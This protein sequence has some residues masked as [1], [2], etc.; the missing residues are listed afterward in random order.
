[1]KSIKYYKRHREV[2]SLWEAGLAKPAAK[3]SWYKRPR[4]DEEK[5]IPAMGKHTINLQEYESCIIF[6]TMYFTDTE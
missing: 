2:K 3:R 5:D 1:M 6:S 4:I